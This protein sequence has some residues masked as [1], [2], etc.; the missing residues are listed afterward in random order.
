MLVW[1]A[2]GIGIGAIGFIDYISG[3]ELRAYPLY[4]GPVGL[5]A[6][7]YGRVGATAAAILSATSWVC[8]NALAGMRFSSEGMWIANT[9]VHATSFL[10]VGILIAT[11][12]RALANERE[13]SRTDSLTRLRNARA[14]YED[15]GPLI[16]LCRRAGR[17]V[18]LAYLDLD[19]FKTVN[20]RYGHQAGDALL[21]TVAQAIRGSVRPSDLCARLAG[22]E[23]AV[24]LPELGEGEAAVAL[25]R[26][27]GAV[28]GVDAGHGTTASLGAVTFLAAFGSLD[29]MIQ[30]ADTLMYAAKAAGGNR[31]TLEVVDRG[32]PGPESS[33][34]RLSEPAG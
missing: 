1:A 6:W 22:D 17:P 2:V 10:F 33:P 18:T 26:I 25:E 5:L 21:C 19:N 31:V 14:F 3:T 20:D 9:A 29:A 8:A 13:L 11:L 23:F 16:A 30:R 12:R 7:H 32:P 15:T 34:S 27:R 4:F 28:N 24:L